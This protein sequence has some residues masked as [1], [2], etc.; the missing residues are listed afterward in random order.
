[1]ASSRPADAPASFTV[2]VRQP[3]PGSMGVPARSAPRAPTDTPFSRPAPSPGYAPEA[4]RPN[5]T[6]VPPSLDLPG[7]D[8]A[9]DYCNDPRFRGTELCQR[10]A[11]GSYPPALSDYCKQRLLALGSVDL[12]RQDELC[13]GSV[14]AVPANVR[15]SGAVDTPDACVARFLSF[16]MAQQA[17]L[18]EDGSL[19]RYAMSQSAA[20]DLRHGVAGAAKV[21]ADWMRRT[22]TPQSPEM[23][24]LCT[25]VVAYERS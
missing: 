21:W 2:Q 11:D 6:T 5:L 18:M 15:P 1:M 12:L 22:F 16:P 25:A 24:E 4:Q 19:G 10:R 8:A 17:T 23:Q 13:A 20:M 14:P 3:A 9:P 7:V